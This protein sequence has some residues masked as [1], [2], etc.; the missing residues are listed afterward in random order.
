MDQ[1]LNSPDIIEVDVDLAPGW[2]ASCR[3]QKTGE[4]KYEYGRKEM[5]KKK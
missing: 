2:L 1:Q 3:I 4:A 5:G